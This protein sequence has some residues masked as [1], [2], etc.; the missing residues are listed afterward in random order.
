VIFIMEG[1]NEQAPNRREIKVVGSAPEKGKRTI[2]EEFQARFK[3]DHF[4]GASPEKE[5]ELK[6]KFKE[7]SYEQGPREKEY[8]KRINEIT[9]RII[10]ENGG[11]IFDV[12]SEAVTF[13]NEKIPRYDKLPRGFHHPLSQ[14]VYIK[15][16]PDVN[17]LQKAIICLHEIIHLKSYLVIEVSEKDKSY[18][19]RGS[20]ITAYR[21]IAVN[22]NLVTRQGKEAPAVGKGL[23]EA[24][25][26]DIE[27][28]H[29]KELIK[30]N[31][32]FADQEE[33]MK[34]KFYQDERR[35]TEKKWELPGGEVTHHNEEDGWEIAPYMEPRKV[36][37]YIESELSTIMRISEKE[38]EKLFY[39]AYFAGKLLPLARAVEEVFGKGAFKKIMHMEPNEESANEIMDFLRQQRK[40]K[41]DNEGI[42]KGI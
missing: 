16:D 21:A 12:S 22:K 39:G 7:I 17:P 31:P 34:Q 38:A 42:K 28:K 14:I 15:G 1:F 6:E 41:E 35:K 26:A 2:E 19:V 24:I 33:W 10:E 25:T 4:I 32:Y 18:D 27:H 5:K 13:V 9:N 11:Q 37:K 23:N 29:W 8:I 3:G 36:L 30:D 20:G 40:S